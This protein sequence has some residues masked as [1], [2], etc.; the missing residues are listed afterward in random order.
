MG[1]RQATA[2][3]VSLVIIL[4]LVVIIIWIA[5]QTSKSR[6]RRVIDWPFEHVE[7]DSNDDQ[8][9][10]SSSSSDDESSD[11]VQTKRR[12][13]G[14]KVKIVCSDLLVERA[15]IFHENGVDVKLTIQG[16]IKPYRIESSYVVQGQKIKNVEP[17]STLIIKITDARGCLTVKNIEI[18]STA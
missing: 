8:S 5:A 16:G 15:F 11:D 1:K 6:T 17:E 9:D 18:P 10:E 13:R 14:M 4:L 7:S 3:L 12:K 2:E